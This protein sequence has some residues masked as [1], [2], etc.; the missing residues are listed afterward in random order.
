M[1]KYELVKLLEKVL[2][3]SYEMKGGE[4]AFHCPFC[5]HHKKKL[6]VNFETQKWHCWVC[7]AG[8]H[9][10]GILL[11][12]INAPKQIISEVLKLLGDY[13]G[14]KNE[15][16]EKTEYNVSLPQCYQP[17]WKPSTDPLYKNAISYLKR[18]GIGGIDILRYSMGYCSSNGYANRIIIPSYDSNGQLNYFVGRDF[19]KGGM[20]YKNP[21]VPKDIIGFDLY[22]NWDEPI[23]LCEGVF[24]AMAIKNNSIPLFGKTI[25]PKLY[26]KI[27]E[28]KVSHVTICLDDDAFKDSLEIASNF[29]DNGIRVNFVKLKGK[30]PSD[31]GYD[32]MITHLNTSTEVNFKELMRMRIYGNR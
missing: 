6:Q 21:P 25:L 32:N 14:V 23:I 31:L 17:L 4:H 26:S 5:N 1:Y 29:M 20:K 12:K 9:K 22:V 13:K 11:R 7:N 3:P 18:R 24:D 30:D 15:K 19:Y 16:D 10:I 27:V 28:K 8:G 2:Y